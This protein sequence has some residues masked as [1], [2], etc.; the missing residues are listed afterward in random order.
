VDL[1]TVAAWAISNGEWA[2]RPVDLSTSLANDLAQALREEKRTDKTG[3]EFRANIPVRTAPDGIPIAT[4]RGTL[5]I[6]PTEIPCAVLKD[7][8]RVLSEN[9]IAN[10][11]GGRSGAAKR[12]K[13]EA[14]KDGAH[15]PVFLA[16]RSLLPFIASDLWDG[17]LKPI[18]YRSGD[19]TVAGY[20]AEALPEI[21]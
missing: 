20:P 4:H 12:L 10:A 21:W 15:L 2:P 8:R 14:E 6:G 13:T 3:R 11:L 5:R 16:S 19:T 17:P 1:R 9:G 7:G 18:I